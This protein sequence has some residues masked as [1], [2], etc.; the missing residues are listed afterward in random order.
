MDP[1]HVRKQKGN[2]ATALNELEKH[3]RDKI[4]RWRAALTETANL[5]GWDS[6]VIRSESK[7]IDKIVEDI[8]WKLNHISSNDLNGLVGIQKRIEKIESLL[9]IGSP[10]VRMVC[11][12]GM[13]GIGKTTLAT[14]VYN[15]LYSQFE[16]G[17]CLAH[18]Q[19]ESE[20]HGLNH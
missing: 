3:F 2:N 9:C 1:S 13:G 17:Y 19:E 14:T 7:L 18:I 20:R 15:S 16:G 5:F 4:Q 12:W 10:D 8:L 11:V 6:Q